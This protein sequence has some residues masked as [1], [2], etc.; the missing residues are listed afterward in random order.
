MSDDKRWER[1]RKQDV[2]IGCLMKVLIA[3]VAFRAARDAVMEGPDLVEKLRAH[4][5]LAESMCAAARNEAEQ[6]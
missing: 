2:L 5:D 4:L 3:R 6:T 1:V